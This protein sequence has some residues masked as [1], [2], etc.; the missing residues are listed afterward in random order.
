[1]APA[2]LRG[3][4]GRP[5]EPW[6]PLTISSADAGQ[7]AVPLLIHG[8]GGVHAER[9][10]H[11]LNPGGPLQP[12]AVER[13]RGEI[14]TLYQD[15]NAYG[16]QPDDT[17]SAERA[18]RFDP[19]CRQKTGY[20]RLDWAVRR[21]YRNRDE[22]LL[23]LK[24]P[25]V[26]LPPHG[27]E[28]DIREPVIRKKIRGGTRRDRGRQCR[29]TFLSLKKTGRKLGLSFWHDLLDRI[30]GDQAI[31]PLPVLIRQRANALAG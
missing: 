31:P 2:G 1:M 23:V 29:D 12:A 21:R 10:L 17:Q 11:P 24:R 9:T 3:G 8:L 26:P 22:W 15:R 30:Q 14:W 28:R 25:E 7:F 19:G 20:A 27:S 4:H 13:G 5:D 16:L 6:K 18:A